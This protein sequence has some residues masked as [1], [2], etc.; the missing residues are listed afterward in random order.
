M[1]LGASSITFSESAAMREGGSRMTTNEK[2]N[3]SVEGD[4]TLKE[5]NELTRCR[6]T[7]LLTQQTQ[8]PALLVREPHPLLWLS[9]VLPADSACSEPSPW[10]YLLTQHAQSPPPGPTCRLGV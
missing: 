1:M 6:R 2:A 3:C 10:S 8:S 7:R 5:R 9:L 4:R